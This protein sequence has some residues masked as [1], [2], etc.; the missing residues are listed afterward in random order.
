M[1]ANTTDNKIETLS[2]RFEFSNGLS[3][4]GVWFNAATASPNASVTIVLNDNGK[5]SAG[6]SVSDALNRGERVLALDLLLTGDAAPESRWEYAALLATTGDRPL[7]IEAA[8]LIALAKWLRQRSAGLDYV[9]VES[10]G[11]RSQAIALAAAA[12]EPALFSEVTVRNGIPSLARLLD[13]AI[14]YQQAP[15]LFCLD[16]YKYFDLDR[17]ADMAGTTKIVLEHRVEPPKKSS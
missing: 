10:I 4:T 7:G 14:P 13:G 3:A 2:Y 16:L 9:R 8:Q 11:M 5:R 15:E 12:L 17:L 6:G 1:L